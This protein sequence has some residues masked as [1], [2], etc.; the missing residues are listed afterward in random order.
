MKSV[1]KMKSGVCCIFLFLSKNPQTSNNISYILVLTYNNKIYWNEGTDCSTGSV[2]SHCYWKGMKSWIKRKQLIFYY[3]YNPPTF[4]QNLQKRY[5]AC[6]V[7]GSLQAR[8]PLGSTVGFSV[9]N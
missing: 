4:F 5:L 1:K 2:T 6:K 7:C 9:L 3:G 8:Y